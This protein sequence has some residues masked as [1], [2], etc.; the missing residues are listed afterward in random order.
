MVLELGNLAL[1]AARRQF[2]VFVHPPSRIL[3]TAEQHGLRTTLDRIGRP[4]QIAALER[5]PT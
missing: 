1:R 4:W 2:Q 3:A 5:P